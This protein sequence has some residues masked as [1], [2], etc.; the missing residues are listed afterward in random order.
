MAAERL[1]R[2]LIDDGELEKALEITYKVLSEDKFY[3]AAY[4]LQMQIFH[5][6]GQYSMVHTTFKL[7][8]DRFQKN[9]N[10]DASLKLKN[11]YSDLIKDK[12]P[13]P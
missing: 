10:A 12:K 1:T 9:F 2:Q 8:R 3:E 5:Q 7:C 6:M 11:L 13:S 4:G